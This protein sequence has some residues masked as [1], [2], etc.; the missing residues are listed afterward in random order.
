MFSIL[1]I[2]P[3]LESA[4]A[5][6]GAFKGSAAQ[7]KASAAVQDALSVITALTPLVQSFGHGAEITPAMVRTALDGKNA[8][9]AE[10]DAEIARHT[11]AKP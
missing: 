1:T 5:V 11:A 2:L 7:A 9:L 3:I 6:F 8:A 10:F 4:L